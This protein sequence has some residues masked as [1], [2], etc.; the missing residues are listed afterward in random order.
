MAARLGPVVVCASLLGCSASLQRPVVTTEAAS[1]LEQVTFSHENELDPAVSPD[2]TSVAYEVTVAPA[3]A[4][5]VVVMKLKDRAVRP[6]GPAQEGARG[7][8]GAQPTWMPD[9]AGLLLVSSA[10]GG[11]LV[12]AIVKEGRATPVLADAG[13]RELPGLW[14]AVAPDGATF[15]ASFP[16]MREFVSGWSA[17]RRFDAALAISDFQ[18]SGLRI[19]GRGTD[20]AWSPDGTQIAFARMT[21][22]H[23][24]LFVSD[25]SGEHVHQVTEGPDDDELPTWSPDGRVLAFC[26][27]QSAE[28]RAKQA[29]LFAIHLDGSR[30]VQLTEGDRNACRPSWS[31]DGFIYFHADVGGQFHIWRLRPRGDWMDR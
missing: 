11:T 21:D 7:V 14:P 27:I 16:N 30:L 3:G 6:P 24:H 20:P 5:Q 31:R 1:D 8:A 29:N 28:H 17:A 13:N 9:G 4:R 19:L 18:G 25:A 15:I 26:S 23:S 22:G 10:R 2:G 12:Q